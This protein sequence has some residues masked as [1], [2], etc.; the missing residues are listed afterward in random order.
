MYT[1]VGY[2]VF[3]SGPISSSLKEHSNI[4]L[5]SRLLFGVKN[6]L[7]IPFPVSFPD[8]QK[9]NLCNLKQTSKQ[10]NPKSCNA[11]QKARDSI[12]RKSKP[13]IGRFFSLKK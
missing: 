11:V 3:I 6:L 2:L 8:G 10:T 13:S 5:F 12:R 9:R 4:N 7:K 1:S